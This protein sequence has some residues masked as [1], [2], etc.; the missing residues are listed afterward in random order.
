MLTPISNPTRLTIL[1]TLARGSVTFSQLERKSQIK[2]NLQFHLNKLIKARLVLKEKEHGKWKY[3][4]HVNGL[5]VL[6]YLIELKNAI[7]V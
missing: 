2:A 5:K 3:F 4:I 7:T 1:K 6:R